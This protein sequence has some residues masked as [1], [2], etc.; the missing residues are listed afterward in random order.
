MWGEER[1][2]EWSWEGSK[3][4]YRDLHGQLC[5]LKKNNQVANVLDLLF[6]LFIYSK[7]LF[8]LYAK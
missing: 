2:K 4:L 6:P 3:Q 1:I 8:L 5:I 7:I